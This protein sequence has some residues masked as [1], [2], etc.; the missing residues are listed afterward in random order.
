MQARVDAGKSAPA[1]DRLPDLGA[2][3]LTL[4]Q[5]W[6]FLN[7]FRPASGMGGAQRIGPRL[8]L[9]FYELRGVTDLETQALIEA[10]VIKLDDEYLKDVGKGTDGSSGSN[11]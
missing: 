3:G 6:Q 4:F 2:E 9:D 7:R 5:V 1:L 10:A 11:D 8:L